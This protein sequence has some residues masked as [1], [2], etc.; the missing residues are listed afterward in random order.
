MQDNKRLCE[1]PLGSQLKRLS[2]G[3]EQLDVYDGIMQEQIKIEIKY[4][5]SNISNISHI[6]QSSDKM[7]N[8]LKS[9][10][11]LTHQSRRERVIDHAIDANAFRCYFA[12]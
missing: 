5:I 9:E 1:K 11:F 12:L 4:Q 8:H 7:R 3:P 2:T 6:M 10:L